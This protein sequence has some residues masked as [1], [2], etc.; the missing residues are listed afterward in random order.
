[1]NQS[2][3]SG[4]IN[5]NTLI[6]IAAIAAAAFVLPKYFPPPSPAPGPGPAPVVVPT[7]TALAEFKAVVDKADKAKVKRMGQYFKAMGDV[8]NRSS[9]S[10]I[11]AGTLR[12]VMVRSDTY[13]V[14]GTD[15]VGSIPGLGAAKDKVI[16]EAVG[17]EDRELVKADLDKVVAAL[18]ALALACG[19][20]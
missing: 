5:N 17:L 10:S 20:Q 13:V 9:S 8:I 12:D 16:T 6:I 15:L 4:G 11:G 18:N 19:V 2:A 1:M 14:Q 3:Q 7:S